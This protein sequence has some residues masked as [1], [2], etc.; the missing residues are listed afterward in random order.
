MVMTY[1][2]YFDLEDYG[3]IRCVNIGIRYFR[4]L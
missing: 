2:Y 4:F 3:S 1:N